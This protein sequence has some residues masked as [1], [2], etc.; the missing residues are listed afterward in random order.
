M[1]TQRTEIEYSNLENLW[2]RTTMM[3]IT[4]PDDAALSEQNVLHHY[5]LLPL[6]PNWG[7]HNTSSFV[8][9]GHMA[10]DADFCRP[11]LAA[12]WVTNALMNDAY[13]LL[14]KRHII[15]IPAYK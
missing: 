9:M 15:I 1:I 7:R 13:C 3:S 12:W 11:G 14:P 10:N 6:F 8:R 2:S 5:Q 4:S